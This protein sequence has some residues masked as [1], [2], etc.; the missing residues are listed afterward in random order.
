MSPSRQEFVS[1]LTKSQKRIYGFIGTLVVNRNDAEDVL[2][3]TN[4]ALWEMA[5]QFTPGT[6]FVAWACKVAHYRVLKQWAATKRLR[7]SLTPEAMNALAADAIHESQLA[8]MAA[9]EQFDAH[10]NALT[11]CLGEV[12]ARNRDLLLQYYEH[13]KSLSDIGLTI[14]RDSNAVAQLF[15]RVRAALRA[16]IRKRLASAST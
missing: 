8:G 12:S 5:D 2:Q 11:A 3:E 6:D 13:G 10:R 4:L 15:H 14:G 9:A 1:L 16:C 7:V